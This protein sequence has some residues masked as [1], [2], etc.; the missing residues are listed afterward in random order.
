MRGM[1][2]AIALLAVLVTGAAWYVWETARD[3]VPRARDTTV[4]SSAP[5]A[6]P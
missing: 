6:R 2:I 3:V 4:P 1:A 5:S